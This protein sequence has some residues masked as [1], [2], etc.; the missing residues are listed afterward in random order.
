MNF[1]KL[2]TVIVS[3]AKRGITLYLLAFLLFHVIVN[4]DLLKLK[5]LNH[6]LPSDSRWEKLEKSPDKLT[7]EGLN[8]FLDYYEHVIQYMPKWAGAYGMLGFCHYYLGDQEK[9]ISFYKKAIDVEPRFFW[10]YFNIGVMHFKNGNYEKSVGAFENAMERNSPNALVFTQLS[11][12]YQDVIR[13]TG[14]SDDTVKKKLNV[15]YHD[16]FALLVSNYYHLKNFPAML[17]AATYMIDADS[18]NT[19]VAYYYAGL[20][21]YEM[22][23]YERAAL[24]LK[25]CVRR[26]SANTYALHY[27]GLC[28][29]ELGKEQLAAGILRKVKSLPQGKN[30]IF[31]KDDEIKIK[32]F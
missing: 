26:D 29:K 12:I 27:L 10:S 2:R 6:F 17:R 28:L 16:C 23:A 25:E 4:N 9:A 14:N 31:S 30:P 15:S 24:L 13:R 21:A 19:D 8:E 11:H 5:A 3:F 7:S 32:I 18:G 20:A 1:N 22:K